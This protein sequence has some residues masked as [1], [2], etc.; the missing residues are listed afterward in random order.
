MKKINWNHL[1]TGTILGLF[2]PFFFLFC[3]WLFVF[4]FMSFIP[5]FFN[6]L[7]LGKIFSSVTSLCVIPN[8]GI[9][10][11]FVNKYKTKSARGVILSTLL[12]AMFIFYL[13]IFIEP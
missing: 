4:S 12:Y 6:Y 2:S 10:F 5:G 9:F 13:K 1:L 11:L 8:L 7:F 3:Y